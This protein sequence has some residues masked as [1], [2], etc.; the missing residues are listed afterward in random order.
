MKKPL[1]TATYHAGLWLGL[2]CLLSLFTACGGSGIPEVPV[3]G[4]VTFGGGR[5]PKPATLDFTAVQPAEG[6]PNKPASVV[7][8]GDGAFEVKLVPG[9]YVVNVTCWEVEM[10]PDN[11]T[12]AKS[13][14]PARFATGAERQKIDVPLNAKGPIELSWDIPKN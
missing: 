13:Y 11:P 10:Q 3:K 1:T 2:C 7:V 6:M 8:E 14:I 12:T 9:Q 5:W 4:K